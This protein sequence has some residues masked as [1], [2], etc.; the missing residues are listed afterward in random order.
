VNERPGWPDRGRPLAI[1]EQ[2]EST[3]PVLQAF[4]SRPP[5]AP[6]YHGFPVIDGAEVDGFRLGMIT[7]FLA[8][9]TDVGDAYVVAPDGSRVGLVWESG[10]ASY[11]NEVSPSMNAAC[12]SSRPGPGSG[13]RVPGR[14]VS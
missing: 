7:D 4:L 13:A 1:D 5:G 9:P 2:A 10:C 11:F 12:S 14:A 8:E 6:V 3:D